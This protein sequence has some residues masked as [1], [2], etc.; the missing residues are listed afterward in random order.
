VIST[1]LNIAGQEF[2]TLINLT[3]RDEMT[4]RML[5][6]RRSIRNEFLVDPGRSYLGGR[7]V[8][9]GQT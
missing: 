7:P 3:T 6:G 2:E 5:L 4:F 1:R 9:L 8:K